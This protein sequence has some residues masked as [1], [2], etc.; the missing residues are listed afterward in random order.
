MERPEPAWMARFEGVR[1]VQFV[2]MFGN[3]DEPVA[4]VYRVTRNGVWVTR[5]E[6]KQRELWH[7]DDIQPLDGRNTP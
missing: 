5:A 4:R 7:P 6:T 1:Y 2:G 3:A